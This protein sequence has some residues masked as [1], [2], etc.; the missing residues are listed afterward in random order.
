MVAIILV[1]LVLY[2]SPSGT[3]PCIFLTG[4]SELTLLYTLCNLLEK[5]QLAEEGTR[6]ASRIMARQVFRDDNQTFFP[7][8]KRGAASDTYYLLCVV[9]P[10][11]KWKEGKKRALVVHSAFLEKFTALSH[12]LLSGAI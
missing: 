2:Y 11:R 12:M 9:K 10:G 3:V 1:V 6:R 4:S 8:F 5:T 7:V